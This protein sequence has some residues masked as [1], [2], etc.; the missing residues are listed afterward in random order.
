MKFPTNYD[1]LPSLAGSAGL[2]MD[3]W[4]AQGGDADGIARTVCH[5]CQNM[6]P[7]A[8]LTED[9]RFDNIC[10]HCVTART[11]LNTAHP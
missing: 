4:E 2:T 7:M 5:G 3:E 8:Q 11:E 6:W 1:T 10:P 9:D